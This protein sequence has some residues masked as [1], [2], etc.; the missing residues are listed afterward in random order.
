MKGILLAG[1][2]GTR[3]Y[4][5]TKTV[6]K[7]LL[8]VYDKP[9]IYYPLSTLML[10]GIQ[11]ILVISTPRDLPGVKELLGGGS[12]LGLK[13]SYKEQPRPEGIPQAFT[14]AAD[15]IGN[16]PV[17]LILGDNLFYGYELKPILEKASAMKSGAAVFAYRVNDPERYGVV[18]FDDARKPLEIVEK[19]HQFIS[20]WAVTGLY[21]FDYRAV[22]YASRLKP[23]ARGET[24]IT[25][26][27][28]KYLEK[29]ELAAYCLGRGMAW[30]DTGTYESLL[31]ASTF[32][33]TLEQRQGLKI[34]CIEEVAYLMGFIDT[35]QL[36]KL[37]DHY[38]NSGYGEYLRRTAELGS[39]PRG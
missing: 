12:H 31:A 32:I 13:L 35:T 22:E 36:I 19:P 2:A 21:F 27:I 18:R 23:S 3:L 6:S 38:P 1:G 24:E 17:A 7:Q 39:Y 26:V 11:E 4:P 28:N 30:L 14:L 33:Q 10:A 25:D 20:P 15:F 34:G 5:L 9:V 8:P 37:A 29:G 16:D